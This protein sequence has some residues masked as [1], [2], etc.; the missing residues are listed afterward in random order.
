MELKG[1]TWDHE[2]GYNPLIPVTEAFCKS[3]PGVNITWAKRSLKD[4][5]D[6]PVSKL[7]ELYDLIMIDHPFMAEALQ[8][9]LLVILNDYI[10]PEYFEMLSKDTVGLSLDSYCVDGK[11][12]A[13]PVDAATQVA[14]A[15][16]EV[17][18]RLGAAVPKTFQQVLDL[19]EQI[20][21]Y[22]IGAGMAA[23]DIFSTF[24]SLVAQ[25]SAP[26]NFHPEKGIIP[27]VGEKAVRMLYQLA[28]ISH[29]DSFGM[30]P[31][32]VLDAMAEDGKIIYTPYIYGYTNY[33]RPGFRKHL[34]TFWDAPLVRE[35]A[36]VST[37]MGGVGIALTKH[38]QPDQIPVA[39]EFAK[40]LAS[41]E[42]QRGMY[43]AADGQPAAY[44]AWMDEENNRIT[45]NFFKNTIQ[46]LETAFV[47]PKIARWNN[48]QE[49]ESMVLHRQIRDKVEPSVIVEKFN[50]LY[51]D[52][53]LN[54]Q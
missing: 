21:D 6:Y 14:V 28:E 19:K 53:C 34:L 24:M 45:G 46:T 52:I 51:A 8:E 1:I 47:R 26:D 7:A 12:Q 17:M 36:G 20:G 16:M 48:F 27:K 44:T 31:I 39:A 5:G 38:L 3:H 9:K 10:E 50:K 49:E 15:N 11:Y 23:T 13:L 2:R 30:N 41:P 37:Q 29:P 4:F 22:C 42:V 18:E 54:R 33:S 43:T 35:D 40:F 25:M 32:Q